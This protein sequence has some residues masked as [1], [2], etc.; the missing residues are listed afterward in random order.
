MDIPITLR[1][2]EKLNLYQE[3]KKRNSKS[4][5]EWETEKRILSWAANPEHHRH[6]HTPLTVQRALDTPDEIIGSITEVGEVDRQR[7]V[8]VIFGNLVARGLAQWS[9]NTENGIRFTRDGFLVGETLNDINE[10]PETEWKYRFVY[11]VSWL[12][13]VAVTISVL[14]EAAKMIA[15]LVCF[16]GKLFSCLSCI[17]H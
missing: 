3:I 8:R 2:F 4:L 14:G 17:C 5:H 12:I 13:F 9:D 15:E 6:M 7:Y 11:V 1:F 16:I 10:S